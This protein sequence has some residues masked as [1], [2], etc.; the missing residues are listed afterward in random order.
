MNIRIGEKIKTLRKARNISQEVLAQYLGVSFQSVSKWETGSAMPDIT[1]VPAIASFFNVST[2]ELFDFNVM[3]MENR[4]MELCYAAA[5]YRHSDP[6]RSEQMLRDALKQYPGND[7]ILN[8]LLYTMQT[9]ERN[10][11]VVELCKALIESTKEDDVKYDALRILAKT[12]HAMG[13]YE[14]TKATLQRIPEIYF[15]KTELD[16]KYLKGEDM[17]Y[18][19]TI[20]KA[21]SAEGLVTMLMRL[22]D[23]Y[24][25]KGETENAVC[26]L[27]LAADLLPLLKAHY[28]NDEEYANFFK[29]F[30]EQE[31]LVLKRLA[32]FGHDR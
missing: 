5:E 9:P 25:E 18:S 27:K 3:E 20:Q 17:F 7:I 10:D 14:L 11:E 1:T 22:G 16:A 31:E 13:E 28:E 32:D 23:Y 12:Y 21:L 24:E 19:A 30:C 4:V 15:S 6:A 26:Q 2:D 29:F 8:N